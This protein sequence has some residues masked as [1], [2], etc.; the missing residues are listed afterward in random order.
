M[1]VLARRLRT[2]YVLGVVRLTP[3]GCYVSPQYALATCVGFDPPDKGEKWH[4]PSLDRLNFYLRVFGVR[5]LTAVFPELL[6]VRFFRLY[7]LTPIKIV[8]ATTHVKS[9]I[10]I[11]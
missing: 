3:E 5:T 2:R 11:L 4:H 10:K 9:I 8:D 6:L 1:D 7:C